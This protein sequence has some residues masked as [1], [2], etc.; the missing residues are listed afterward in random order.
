MFILHCN[1]KPVVMKTNRGSRY[2]AFK[3]F[4]DGEAYL[5]WKASPCKLSALDEILQLNPRFFSKRLGVLLLSSRDSIDLLV[6][7]P[8]RFPTDEYTMTLTHDM[9]PPIENPIPSTLPAENDKQDEFK[10]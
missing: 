4:E 1:G 3:Y 10:Y 2:V 9:P 6:S 8:Q 7:D 5:K